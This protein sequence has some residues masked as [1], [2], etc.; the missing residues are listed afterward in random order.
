[1]SRPKSNLEE[2]LLTSAAEL[3]ATE[4]LEALS[5]RE[6]GRR[7]GVSRAAP[8]HYFADK[9]ELI[10]RVGELGFRRLGD[11]ITAATAK[12]KD[13]LQQI[14]AGLRAY[15]EFARVEPD[16]FQLMFSNALS[17]ARNDPASGLAFSSEAARAAFATLIDGV[18]NAQTARV[19]RKTDPLLIVNVLWAFTHGVAVLARDQHLKHAGGTEA[20]FDAGFRALVEHYAPRQLK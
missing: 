4:G 2:Q 8:Y 14:R 9:A 1:M 10:A 7:A 18:R 15:I 11:T 12:A 19:L 5:L 20:V 6:L 16:F 3:I 17:R 13:P